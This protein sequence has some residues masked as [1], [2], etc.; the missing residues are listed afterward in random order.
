MARTD[1]DR[2][3]LQAVDLIQTAGLIF[4]RH[5]EKIG[6][7]FDLVSQSIIVGNSNP[8]FL[9]V[10]PGDLAEEVVVLLFPCSQEDKADVEGEEF[11]ENFC[12]EVE[13][14]LIGQPGDHP[15][16]RGVF[17]GREED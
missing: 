14:L 11:I 12:Q 15:E 16:E 8:C 13:S 6:S 2:P 9:R 4:R 7:G 1:R 3:V 17:E 10:F 5:E